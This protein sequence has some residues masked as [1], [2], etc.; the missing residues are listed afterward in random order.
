VNGI[1]LNYISL[2]PN[3]KIYIQG[4]MFLTMIQDGNRIRDMLGGETGKIT[5]GN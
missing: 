3:F 1:E 2:L 4:Q 5:F